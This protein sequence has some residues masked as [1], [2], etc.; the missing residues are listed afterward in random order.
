M[1]SN[2][3]SLFFRGVVLYIMVVQWKNV[4]FYFEGNIEERMALLKKHSEIFSRFLCLHIG[5][6]RIVKFRRTLLNKV[7]NSILDND[8][9]LIGSISEGLDMTGSDIDILSCAG[10]AHE[11]GHGSCN[12]HTKYEYDS[13]KN[14]MNPGYVMIEVKGYTEM[15]LFSNEIQ[16]LRYAKSNKNSYK[17]VCKTDKH[18]PAIMESIGGHQTDLIFSI[19]SESWPKIAMEWITRKR[20][21]GWP[22]QE[23]INSIIKKGC[24]IVPVGSSRYHENDKDWRLSFCIAER[25]LI[26]TFNHTQILVYGVLK[27]VLKEIL[28][29]N[30]NEQ[31]I[32][33][34]FLKTIMF[35]EVEETRSSNWIPQKLLLCFQLCIRRFMKFVDEENC[36]NYFVRN[37]NMFT[38]RINSTNKDNLLRVLYDI[39][40]NGW[41]WLMKTKPLERFLYFIEGEKSDME[42][43]QNT[44]RK[45]ECF[46]ISNLIQQIVFT[47]KFRVCSVMSKFI[48]AKKHEL[49]NMI[50]NRFFRQQTVSVLCHYI[51]TDSHNL[52]NKVLYAVRK[53]H[54]QLLIMGSKD[55]LI[56]GKILLAS[57]LYKQGKYHECL[58]VTDI[59]MKN[60]DLGMF[61]MGK[62]IMKTDLFKKVFNSTRNFSEIQ[63]LSSF[64]LIFPLESLLV[65]KELSNM[66]G[67]KE[68]NPLYQYGYPMNLYCPRNYIYFLRCLC[69]FKFGD[70]RKCEYEYTEMNSVC[71]RYCGTFNL[72]HKLSNMYL[73]KACY[74]VRNNITSDLNG[75]FESDIFSNKKYL[76]EY[77]MTVIEFLLKF[78]PNECLLNDLCAALR[79]LPRQFFRTL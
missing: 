47:L 24:Y 71:A 12:A 42:M 5:T 19:K 39:A 36:P 22:S 35:W 62:R 64:E 74:I 6:E 15:C 68:T 55:D 37:N 78:Q 1:V 58:Q 50:K 44:I 45:K 76:R 26:A 25:E 29:K 7:M 11:K 3:F 77:L 59:S 31:L 9:T 67:T 8:D 18:G 54:M 2:S 14:N 30:S 13:L 38:E 23:M 4:Y 32:C 40:N 75:Q 48:P 17:N 70:T 10:Q 57:W 33:S 69:Y 66:F 21:F 20:K 41:E 65:E 51:D 61:H 28:N 27:L 72:Q 73:L 46:D 63:H 56:C 43:L 60:L 16:E 79:L 49:S 34:Y 52:E 53:L